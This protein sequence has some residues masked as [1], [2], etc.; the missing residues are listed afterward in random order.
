MSTK[1]STTPWSSRW[2]LKLNQSCF[3]SKWPTCFESA[4]IL[5]VISEGV[6]GSAAPPVIARVR[7]SSPH[8]LIFSTMCCSSGREC[9]RSNSIFRL[10]LRCSCAAIIIIWVSGFVFCLQGALTYTIG[11]KGKECGSINPFHRKAHWLRFGDEGHGGSFDL[12]PFKW[13]PG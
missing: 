3:L 8:W 12:A 13:N 1:S 2:N 9:G 7:I 11:R 10:L 5:E 6:C 4:R